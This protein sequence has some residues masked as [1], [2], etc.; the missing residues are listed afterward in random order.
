MVSGRPVGRPR[1]GAPRK[2]R[3]TTAVRAYVAGR[4]AG[5][6]DQEFLAGDLGV[7]VNMSAI[8]RASG[9]LHW[10]PPNYKPRGRAAGGPAPPSGTAL[11]DWLAVRTDELRLSLGLVTLPVPGAQAQRELYHAL[12]SVLGVVHLVR[13]GDGPTRRVVALVVTDGDDDRRRLRAELEEYA[14]SWEW[15]EVDE[16]TVNPAVQTWR[17]L[18]LLA[19]RDEDLLA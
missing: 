15:S 4:L 17:H 3:S 10:R 6:L 19:A 2:E 1:E 5:R 11:R 12:Q 14:D 18:T 8:Q 9:P 16:E 7:A 13:A